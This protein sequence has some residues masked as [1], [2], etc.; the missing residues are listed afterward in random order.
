MLYMILK[1]MIVKLVSNKPLSPTS[2]LECFTRSFVKDL[3]RLLSKLFNN[4]QEEIVNMDVLTFVP[5]FMKDLLSIID[6]GAVFH[7][8]YNYLCWLNRE[9]STNDLFLSTIKFTFISIITDTK[10]YIPL[11]LPHKITYEQINLNSLATFW[12]VFLI[13]FPT[14]FLF[15]FFLKYLKLR[16]RNK[17]QIFIGFYKY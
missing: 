6:R 7:M 11:N 16:S 15:L 4:N 17:I 14:F 2:R 3:K 8:I 12:F 1:S 10:H 9:I 13:F 5:L